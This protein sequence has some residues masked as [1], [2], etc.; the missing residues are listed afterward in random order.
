MNV[1][2]TNRTLKTPLLGKQIIPVNKEDID[3][4]KLIEHDSL[5]TFKTGRNIIWCFS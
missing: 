2:Y 3:T 1:Y 5:E 4:I